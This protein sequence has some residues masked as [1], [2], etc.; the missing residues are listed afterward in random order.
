MIPL[1]GCCPG[2]D[3]DPRQAMRRHQER[4]L[5]MLR[6]WRD[7]AERQLAALDA[8]ISTLEQQMQRAAQEPQA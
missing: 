8:S 6:F 2:P 3:A 7:A 5:R 1:F 4:R